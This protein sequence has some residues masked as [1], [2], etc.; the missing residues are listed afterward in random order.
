MP[1]MNDFMVDIE[2]TGTDP[3][4]AAMIQLAAVRFSRETG[5]VDPDM[6]VVS[7]GIPPNR[8]WQE[9]T[10]RWWSKMPQVLSEIQKAAIP[11]AEAM[12]SLTAWVSSKQLS[13]APR[14][15]AK[16]ISFDWPFVE[17]YF[18]TFGV[19]SPFHFRSCVDVRTYLQT[20]LGMWD[21]EDLNHWEKRTPFQGIVH[22]A[23]F[24]ALHQIR[25]V[26]AAG[27]SS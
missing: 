1:L 21:M 9:D 22:D 13:G 11:P 27:A 25:L 19:L 18:Q 10:R 17:S 20:K 23:R 14:F 15:W 3:S 6:F 2:T 26:L 4:H 16:P 7:L 5:E 8:F 24:D 12:K